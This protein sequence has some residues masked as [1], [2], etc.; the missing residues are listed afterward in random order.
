MILVESWA[1]LVYDHCSS[2][3]ILLCYQLSA[4]LSD[5]NKNTDSITI[6]SS[7]STDNVD[8]TVRFLNM[9]SYISTY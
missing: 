9:S 8:R 2:H 5:A 3:N 6:N 7:I 4:A 1:P